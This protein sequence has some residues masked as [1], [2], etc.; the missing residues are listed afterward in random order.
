MIYDG[1]LKL[2]EHLS[3]L[4][5]SLSLWN[6][7]MIQVRLC[8]GKKTDNIYAMKMLKKSEMLSRGQVS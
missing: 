5:F 1:F 4:V 2:L 8:R 7:L 6:G 3:Y